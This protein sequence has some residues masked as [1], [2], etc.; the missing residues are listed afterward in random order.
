MADD[1][2]E[3]AL[4]VVGDHVVAP[5][6]ERPGARHALEREAA[7]HRR[8]DLDRVVAARAA[9]ELDGP[10]LQ[11]RVDVDLLDRGEHVRELADA[12]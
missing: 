7:A 1:G 3:Q 4:D 11:Q 12:R 10:L 6:D 9:D 2:S 8:A 5:V